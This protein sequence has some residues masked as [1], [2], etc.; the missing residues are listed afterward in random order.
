MAGVVKPDAPQLRVLQAGYGA[1]G[2]VHAR[3]WGDLGFGA[4]LTIADPDPGAL[5]RAR[6]VAPE[7]RC[8]ED[9][10]SALGDVDVADIVS[11]SNTHVDVALAALEAGC[12][13]L[14]E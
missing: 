12:V 6:S 11:P 10:R 4:R 1:F 7:A 9:W 13:V 3:A 5:A 2:A 8:V 14:I